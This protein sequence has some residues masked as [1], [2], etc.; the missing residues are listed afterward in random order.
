M[1][2]DYLLHQV[3]RLYQSIE[4]VTYNRKGLFVFREGDIG[5][6]FYMV[7]TGQGTC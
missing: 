3:D 1:V 7:F 4:V 2:I 6:N 5:E